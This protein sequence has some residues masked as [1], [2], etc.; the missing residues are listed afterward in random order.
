MTPFEKEIAS[1]HRVKP[2]R[3]LVEPASRV[4][5]VNVH[6]LRPIRK[7]A[8]WAVVAIVWIAALIPVI[9]ISVLAALITDALNH[10]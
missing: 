5:H 6:A 8:H 9:A 7:K 4:G 1:L 3:L 10:G 2:V